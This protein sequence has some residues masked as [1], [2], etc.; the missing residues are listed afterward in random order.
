M[1]LEQV[2]TIGQVAQSLSVT[3]KTVYRMLSDGRLQ[4]VKLGTRWRIRVVD[5]DTFL[6]KATVKR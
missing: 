6:R 3:K 1:E 5:L 2:Y 4:G